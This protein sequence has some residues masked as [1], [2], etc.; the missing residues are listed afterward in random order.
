MEASVETTITKIAPG[1][2]R[3]SQPMGDVK[4]SVFPEFYTISTNNAYLIEGSD[5]HMLYLAGYKKGFQS[6]RAAVK[7]LIGDTKKIGYIAL[8]VWASD[9]MGA[10]RLWLDECP[11]AVIV[12]SRGMVET[13]TKAKGITRVKVSFDGVGTGGCRSSRP[14]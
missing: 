8:N 12:C 10:L 1:L 9:Q 7:S 4:G 2:T 14:C 6:L 13:R 3:L 5:K 11:D